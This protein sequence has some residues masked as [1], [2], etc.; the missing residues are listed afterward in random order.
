MIETLIMLDAMPP[1]APL[2][3]PEQDL[4]PACVGH[5]RDQHHWMTEPLPAAR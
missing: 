3:M 1:K 4:G 5:V 2:A